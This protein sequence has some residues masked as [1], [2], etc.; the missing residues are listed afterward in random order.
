MDAVIYQEA[1]VEKDGR[2][3]PG[4]MT[5]IPV[6]I[7]SVT[8]HNDYRPVIL[9]GEERDRVLAKMQKLSEALPSR[10]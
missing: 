7:S 6:R 8:T 10:R 1:F 5:I 3:G 2:M 9:A 4:E